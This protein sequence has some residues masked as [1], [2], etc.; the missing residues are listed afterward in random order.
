MVLMVLLML[1]P[2]AGLGQSA[3]LPMEAT[4]G[5]PGRAVVPACTDGV[6]LD[7]GEPETGYG[8]VPSVVEGIYVQELEVADLPSRR[9][10]SVCICWMRSRA[11]ETL[12]FEV[13][14]YP[15]VDGAPALEP[16]VVVPA[17]VQGVP[18]ALD[19]VF[20]EVRLPG[21]GVMVG[22][23]RIYVG[24]RWD[25]SV[26]QFFFVCADHT[27]STPVVNGF[28]IDDRA[29]EWE[30]VLETSDPIFLSHRAMLIRVVTA[31]E[32]GFGV[33]AAGTAGL[34]LLAVALACLAMLRLRSGQG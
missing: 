20:A 21:D 3:G 13:V 17:S 6:V 29:D 7:D 2:R 19:G 30:S 24:A 28:F 16:A 26:D 14:I 32:D 15:E 25:A 31:A 22:S 4:A 34:I 27:E 9:L 12:D 11:D 10:E 33:P 5:V 1:V 8:W 18:Q 23:D